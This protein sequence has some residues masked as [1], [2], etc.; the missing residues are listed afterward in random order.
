M[1]WSTQPPRETTAPGLPT[2]NGIWRVREGPPPLKFHLR[3]LRELQRGNGTD[4]PQL[5]SS[6]GVSS[7]MALSRMSSRSGFIRISSARFFKGGKGKGGGIPRDCWIPS[8]GAPPSAPPLHLRSSS[9]ISCFTFSPFL[10]STRLASLMDNSW[11]LLMTCPSTG[12][13][14]SI[15]GT[16]T[17]E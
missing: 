11:K 3:T 4:L 1:V 5:P 9:S 17:G 6:L 12:F 10:R 15:P 8:G 14:R 7:Y 13:S 16:E 2:A